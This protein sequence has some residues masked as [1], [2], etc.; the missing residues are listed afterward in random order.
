MHV[1]YTFDEVIPGICP[2]ATKPETYT[3]AICLYIHPRNFQFPP[4]VC[5]FLKP[6]F[7]SR[8]YIVR[9]FKMME[10][11]GTADLLDAQHLSFI[12]DYHH[13][14]CCPEKKVRGAF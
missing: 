6:Q 10:L 11:P 7:F 2:E 1:I 8:L 3:W 13:R 12:S 5:P 9:S 4:R 14:C